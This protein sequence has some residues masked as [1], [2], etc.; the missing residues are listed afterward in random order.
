MPRERDRSNRFALTRGD[1][2]GSQ[3][4]WIREWAMGDH[5]PSFSVVRGRGARIRERS[6]G[7]RLAPRVSELAE[8]AIYFPQPVLARP[9][10]AAGNGENSHHSRNGASRP[11]HSRLDTARSRG[12]SDFGRQ[13]Y[14]QKWTEEEGKYRQLWHIWKLQTQV[15]ADYGHLWPTPTSEEVRGTGFTAELLGVGKWSD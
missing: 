14:R 9:I 11:R 1:R 12:T 10:H 8:R 15:G 5:G 7:R 3:R 13:I 2:A 4:G 6:E